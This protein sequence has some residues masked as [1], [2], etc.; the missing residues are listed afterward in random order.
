MAEAREE[1]LAH[2]EVVF[3]MINEN[4]VGIATSVG[5]DSYQFIC[6]CATT[7]CF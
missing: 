4:I 6:E 5:G 3:R 7:D 1:R 2:N